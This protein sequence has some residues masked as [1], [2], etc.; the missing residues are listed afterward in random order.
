MIRITCESGRV[1]ECDGQVFNVLWHLGNWGMWRTVHAA[2]VNPG[3]YILPDN[4]SDPIEKVKSV[5]RV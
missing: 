2:S 1:I 4:P 3:D 5:E